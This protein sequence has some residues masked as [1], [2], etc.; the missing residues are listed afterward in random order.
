MGARQQRQKETGMKIKENMMRVLLSDSTAV[1][2]TMGMF[3]F[4]QAPRIWGIPQDRVIALF[5]VFFG[6]VRLISVVI[7][8][9]RLRLIVAYCVTFMWV[10]FIIFVWLEAPAEYVTGGLASAA[11]NIWIAWRLQTESHM[12]K[13]AAPFKRE[14][15]N[16]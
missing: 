15:M 12:Y 5:V 16:E 8:H 4:A 11:I 6:A 10:F 14:A 9:L 3:A 1:E 2:F 7:G 13:K